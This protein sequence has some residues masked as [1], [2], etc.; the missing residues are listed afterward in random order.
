MY[1]LKYHSDSQASIIIDDLSPI[2]FLSWHQYIKSLL[3]TQYLL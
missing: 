2:N 3:R 1:D